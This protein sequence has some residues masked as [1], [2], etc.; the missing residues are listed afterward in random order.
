MGRRRLEPGYAGK[1]SEPKWNADRGVWQQSCLIGE[2]IGRPSRV[3]A[4]GTTKP[5]CKTALDKAVK[6][7]KPRAANVGVYSANCTVTEAVRAWLASRERDPNEKPQTLDSYRREIELSTG[8]GADPDKFVICTSDLGEMRAADVKPVH[9]RVHLELLNAQGGKQRQHKSILSGTFDML[10]EDGLIDHNPVKS[11]KG[12]RGEMA[13]RAR[14]SGGR[15]PW[16]DDEPQPFTA[17]EFARYR[18]L[19]ADY[20]RAD[21]RRDPRYLDFSAL[22]YEIAARPGEVLAL[23]WSDIDLEAATVEVAATIVSTRVSVSKVDAL[24]RRYRLTAGEMAIRDGWRKL[25][26]DELVS[27]TY[28]QPFPKTRESRRVIKVGPDVLAMLR[29]RKLA[30]RP[31]QTLVFPSGTGRPLGT[32]TMSEM[33]RRI[34]ADTELSWS[35]PR[36][37]RSTRATRVAERHGIPAARLILGHE[38]NSP[39]TTRHYVALA[40]PVVDYAD[41]R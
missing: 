6:N 33:W 38:E 36:T 23:R 5:K 39:V 22:A 20:I 16:F 4:S 31:G 2:P 24:I 19:E 27:V 35:T 14:P 3:H 28:R 32:S 9:V 15:N 26:A 21:S 1:Y 12:R 17:A 18:K 34:V 40:T 25:G 13:E 41:A 30:A 7:W 37:L 10:V 11:V 8:R 29:R